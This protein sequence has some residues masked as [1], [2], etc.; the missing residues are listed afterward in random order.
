MKTLQILMVLVSLVTIVSCTKKKKGDYDLDPKETLSVN[1]MTEPP[2]LDWNKS[3]DTT[4]AKIQDNIMEGMVEYDFSD[5][6][7]GLVG[8][9]AKSWTPANEAKEWTF[10]LKKNIKWTDGVEVTAQH[11]IDSWE[12]LLNPN[13]ASEYAYFLYG[14]ENAKEYNQ[15]AIKDFSKVGAK[16]VDN[17]TIKVKLTGSQS[18]FP[19]LLTHHSTYPIRV[20]VIKEHGDKWT[21]P[22]NMVTNGPFKMK[23]WDHDKAIILERNDIYFGE[24]PKIKNVIA[25]MIPEM[26]TAINLFDKGKLDAQLELPSTELGVLKKKDEY[27]GA[28]ILSI[29]YYGFNVKKKPMDNALVRKAISHA[30]NRNEVTEMLAGGQIPLTS[31]V[32]PG[33]FGYEAELGTSFDVEQANKL[34]DKA[35]YKD[36]SKFPT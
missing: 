18:Y 17:Y 32:P 19:Y 34:L 5:P 3:T 22:E 27:S 8:S 36:R 15:G 23:V 9:I 25:Y 26:S 13:T 29:Y 21:N 33:M 11:F 35:G 16:A 24:K 30:I 4:S 6:D 20:D 14:L 1:I 31:W 28:G 2:S 10:E 7:L 12:R